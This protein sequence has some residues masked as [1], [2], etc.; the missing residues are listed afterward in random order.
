MF[1]FVQFFKYKIV[2]KISRLMTKMA[3][4]GNKLF[5]IC[6]QKDDVLNAK[7]AQ[8]GQRPL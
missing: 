1:F 2:F 7:K 3:T 6:C 8:T 4:M 5:N